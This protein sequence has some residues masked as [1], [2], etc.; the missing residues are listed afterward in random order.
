MSELLNE[1]AAVTGFLVVKTEP[2]LKVYRPKCAKRKA[3]L[4]ESATLFE[5]DVVNCPKLT[6][7]LCSTEIAISQGNDGH[8]FKSC[9]VKCY[10]TLMK[11]TSST[12]SK[13]LKNEVDNLVFYWSTN[14]HLYKG[15]TMS[16]FLF[17]AANAVQTKT[18]GQV[19]HLEFFSSMYLLIFSI[20]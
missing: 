15:M 13:W 2:K 7:A 1:H 10:K 5:C 11:A 20:L 6:H 18:S 17:E 3:C 19:S 12:S 9:S 14:N 8:M 4:E 16:R